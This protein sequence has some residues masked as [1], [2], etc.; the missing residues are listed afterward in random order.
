VVS[1]TWLLERVFGNGTPR[2]DGLVVEVLRKMI[3][4]VSMVSVSWTPT[5][6]FR[7]TAQ[8]VA[9]EPPTVVQAIATSFVFQSASS[10]RRAPQLLGQ[11]QLAVAQDVAL[12][13]LAGDR[14]SHPLAGGR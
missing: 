6:A 3:D 5:P 12:D 8:F 4:L 7:C 14:E 13:P 9:A 2:N 1:I 10:R 11:A